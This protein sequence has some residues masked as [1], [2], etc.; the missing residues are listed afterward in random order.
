MKNKNIFIRSA[1]VMQQG[2]RHVNGILTNT[3]Q[4]LGYNECKETY[5]IAK[6]M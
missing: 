6:K 2:I 1:E 4:L 5:S 3:G